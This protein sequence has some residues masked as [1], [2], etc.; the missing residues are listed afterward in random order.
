MIGSDLTKDS[1][2]LRPETATSD[3]SLPFSFLR[4]K[5]VVLTKPVTNETNYEI[6]QR[7]GV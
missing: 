6:T 5:I 7:V 1:P 4:A 3:S 2:S